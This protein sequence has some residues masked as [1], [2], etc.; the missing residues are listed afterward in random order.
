MLARTIPVLIVLSLP[1]AAQAED[2][3]FVGKINL[4]VG[5]SIVI[6]GH[7]GECGALP[8]DAD[9]DLPT[10]ETGTLSIGKAGQRKSKKCNGMTP[11]V[12]IIF[13]ATAPGREKFE[14]DG[15]DF[16]ARVK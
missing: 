13:T 4:D 11:A 10:L 5:Q 2:I 12:E 8:T 14:I 1:F 15:D 9:I 3:P 7:R 6:Y 16:T